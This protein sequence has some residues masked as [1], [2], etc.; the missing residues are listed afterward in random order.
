MIKFRN[1]N[2]CS[3]GDVFIT[4]GGDEAVYQNKSDLHTS[5]PHWLKVDST[6]RSYT[7]EGIHNLNDPFNDMRLVE[8]KKWLPPTNKLMD[9]IDALQFEIDLLKLE[10]RLQQD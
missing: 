6:D 4:A 9:K 1:L 7:D 3:P 10:V 2:D 5:Y 8:L